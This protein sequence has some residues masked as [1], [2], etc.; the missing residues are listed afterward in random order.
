M[1]KSKEE[2]VFIKK[3]I[4]ILK[5]KSLVRNQKVKIIK[6]ARTKENDI[7]KPKVQLPYIQ[8]LRKKDSSTER[9]HLQTTDVNKVNKEVQGFFSLVQVKQMNILYHY[10][11]M[12]KN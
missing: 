8:I 5:F 4:E 11:M 3:Y 1:S 2:S 12:M 9:Y 7:N 6:P 10:I